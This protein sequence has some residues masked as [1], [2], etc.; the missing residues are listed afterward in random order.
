MASSC[1]SRGKSAVKKMKYGGAVKKMKYGG[2]VQKMKRGG[3]V[4][5][6]CRVRN[7]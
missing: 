2:S 6:G 4:K 1:G 5:T 3:K 7:A